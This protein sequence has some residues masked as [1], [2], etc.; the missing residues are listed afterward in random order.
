[1]IRK[2]F[3]SP[4]FINRKKRIN[5]QEKEAAGEGTGEGTGAVREG[6]GADSIRPSSHFP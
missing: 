1:M 4:F 3:F 6:E 2:F 5:W